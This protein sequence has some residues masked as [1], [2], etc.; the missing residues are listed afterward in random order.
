MSGGEQYPDEQR[1]RLL[2]GAVTLV[3]SIQDVD[4]LLHWLV[5]LLIPEFADLAAV[6]RFDGETLVPVAAG[7]DEEATRRVLDR[8]IPGDDV[9]PTARRITDAE[10]GMSM[11]A[12]PI[13]GRFKGYPKGLRLARY[14]E[15]SPFD[16]DDLAVIQQLGQQISL[17]VGALRSARVAETAEDTTEAAMARSRRLQ[18]LTTQLA[19]AATARQVCEMTAEHMQASLRVAAVWITLFDTTG[20]QL[21]L[22]YDVGVPD[23]V[24]QRFAQVSVQ[25]WSAVTTAATTRE[26][27]WFTGA[28]E[29]HAAHPELAD[30][31]PT[32]SSAALLPLMV[33]DH[34]LGG[35]GVCLDRSGAFSADERGEMLA[36]VGL[37]AQALERAQRFDVAQQL[38]VTLQRSLLPDI[39]D[40]AGVRLYTHY[41]PA[42]LQ[43]QVGGDWYDV[44]P[45]NGDQVALVVGDVAGHG[46]RAATVMGQIRTG[47]R[48]Y[49]LEGHDPA[50]ALD[51]AQDLMATIIPTLM[52]T[53]W[54]GLLELTT[55]WLRYATAGHLPPA[56]IDPAGEV[57][58]L[59]DGRNPPLGTGWHGQFHPAEVRLE[60]ETVLVCYTDGLV[61]RRDEHL[62]DGLT[63][64]TDTLYETAG[65]LD[66]F[67]ELVAPLPG[68]HHGD[69]VAILAM[70]R[71]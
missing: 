50:T 36:V 28:D 59:N 2:T 14:A 9:W 63:R 35:M 58:F 57:A 11:I 6:D 23:D 15:R 67:D 39:R 3:E 68:T 40:T 17:E 26:A 42:A 32:V 65:K 53:V 66:Q 71:Q 5:D 1:H 43:S 20:T 7:P 10:S 41:S 64:L 34:T 30:I 60:R 12:S 29:S 51:R 13:S 52:T 70:R 55:G 27:V 21:E 4:E 16:K 47:L 33:G 25:E 24:R 56:V 69:D 48:A 19:S 44:V 22:A 54:C 18:R 61:E 31:C 46:I 49:L 8:V 38:A 62:D 37:C 45:V